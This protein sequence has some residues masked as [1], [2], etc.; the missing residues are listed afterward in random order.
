MNI[1]ITATQQG[2]FFRGKPKEIIERNLT[3]AM[4]ETTAFLEREVKERTPQGVFGERGAGL[5]NT[6][7]GEVSHQGTPVVLGVVSHQ[8][9]YGN[10]IALGRRPG[11]KMPPAGSLIDWI[12]LKLDGVDEDEA[13]DIEYGVRRNIAKFGFEGVHMFQKAVEEN[14]A[15]VIKIFQRM[16]FDIAREIN[17]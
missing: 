13:E 12:V 14:W 6:I 8:S 4:Y 5:R 9:L 2:N 16:G 1:T 15:K 11:R 3:S 17:R 7:Y 10:V